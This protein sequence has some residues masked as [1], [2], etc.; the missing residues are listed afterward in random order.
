MISVPSRFLVPR[1]AKPALLSRQGRGHL[2]KPGNRWFL[3]SYTNLLEIPFSLNAT[4]RAGS[5][6]LLSNTWKPA[7]HPLV[8]APKI[9]AVAMV[10]VAAAFAFRLGF[11]RRL[12]ATFKARRSLKPL[13]QYAEIPF[14]PVPRNPVAPPVSERFSFGTDFA[15]LEVPGLI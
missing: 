3:P 6:S 11:L 14:V 5:H 8:L 4:E 15:S 10:L 13:L 12:R 1:D 7:H 2:R 9:A